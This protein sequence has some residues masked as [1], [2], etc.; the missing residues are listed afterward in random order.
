MDAFSD[1]FADDVEVLENVEKNWMAEY[2]GLKGMDG[3]ETTKN[4]T[5]LD[6]IGLP[7]RF[8]L[9]VDAGRRLALGIAVI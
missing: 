8:V 9:V 3:R 1:E 7:K 4:R 6:R 2:A 5:I